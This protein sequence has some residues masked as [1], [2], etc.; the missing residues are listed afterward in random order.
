MLTNA[1]SNKKKA[2]TYLFTVR[3][4]IWSFTGNYAS[5][6]CDK[7]MSVRGP[8]HQ[9]IRKNYDAPKHYIEHDRTINV[10]VEATYCP[11]K[12]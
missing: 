9:N 12:M 8:F 10:G 1:F 4:P 6:A 7:M 5:V 11:R 3:S 2:H